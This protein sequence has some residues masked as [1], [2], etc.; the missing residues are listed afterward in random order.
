MLKNYFKI[1]VKVLL[2]RKFFT[3]ISLFGISFTLV[4]LMVVTAALDNMFSPLAPETKQDRTL[5]V[6]STVMMGKN[7]IMT[8]NVGYGFLSRFVKTLSD[9]EMVS[10]YG[11]GGTVSAYK[12]GSEIKLTL[13]RTDGEYWKILD[14]RFLEG[15]PITTD[16]EAAANYVCVINEATRDRYFGGAPALGKTI[17]FDR[18]GYRVCGV[19]PNVPRYRDIPF[20]DVWVPVST[21]PDADYREKMTGSFYGLILAHD[22]SDFDRIKQELKSRLPG[23]PLPS[24]NFD[25]FDT[26]AESV[27]ETAAREA[28]GAQYSTGDG[29]DHA[30]ESYA[31]TAIG[32]MA[33]AAFLFMLLPTINLVN[34]NVSRM[35]ERSSE[36]GVRK[37][38]G[39]SSASL[40]GQ[41]IVENL[42]LTAIGGVLGFIGTG[43]ILGM[44]NQSGLIQYAHFTMN[45]R[46]FLYGFLLILAFGVI[47]G[48][49]PAWRM[50]RMH[51]V[52]ALRGVTQ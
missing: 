32:I 4:V 6:F 12:D 35:I 18:R 2:R 22:A 24:S 49:Y 39:A 38:F 11:S 7:Y 45:L 9:V 44:L 17:A 19:V 1:A 41:F 8:G 37:S 20:A 14:F 43:V 23:V 3:V 29:G 33:L 5:G 50:A 52:N 16:D 40:V 26:R 48:A 46:V 51:P 31:G 10:I 27:F 36:I 15:G 47:S 30:I 13:K 21:T 42:I 34:I 28:V 25:K